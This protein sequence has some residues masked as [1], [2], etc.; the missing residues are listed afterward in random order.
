[1]TSRL[2]LRKALRDLRRRRSQIAAV[3]VT[4]FLGILLFAA[5]YDAASNLDASYHEVYDRLDFADVWATGG[6]TDEIVAELQAD[7]DVTAIGTRTRFDA[8]LRIGD[9]ELVGTVIGMPTDGEPPLNRLWVL[10]GRYFEPGDE[11]TG[12][13]IIEQHAR[14]EFDLAPGDAIGILGDDG[15]QELELTGAAASAEYVWLAPNRQQLFTV[16][17]EF[18]VVFVPEPVARDL[19]PEVPL[20][21]VAGVVDHRDDTA[22]RLVAATRSAGA[23]DA[24]TRSEQASNVTLQNDVSGFEQ[25][26]FVFPVLFL[27]VAGIAALVLLSRLVRTER[28]QIGMMVANG[29]S[30]RAIRAHYTTHALVAVL[31]GAIPGLILGALLGRW[32]SS[33]YTAFLDIPVTVTHFSPATIMISLAFAVVVTALAG[34]LPARAAA[35]IR[36]AEAM[37][38]PTPRAVTRRSLVERLWPGSLPESV[39]MVVRNVTRNRRRFVST[40]A[41]V[42]LALMMIITSLGLADT[43]AGAF[44]EQFDEVDLRDLTVTFDAPVTD[45]ELAQLD[46]RSDVATAERFVELPVVF[47]SPDGTSDQLLQ[48]FERDTAAHGFKTALPADGI[49]LSELAAD[50]L[51]VDIGD[52]ITVSVPTLGGEE[53]PSE[54]AGGTFRFDATVSGIVDEPVPSISYTSIDTWESVGAPPTH[55]AVL[56]LTDPSSHEA[57]RDAIQAAPGI[58]AVVD[59]QATESALRD[60]MALTYLF[61]ALMLAFSVIMAIALVYNM[62]SVSLAERTGEVAALRANGVGHRFIRRTVTTENLLTMLAGIVPGTIVGL[63]LARSFLQQFDTDSITFDFVLHGRSLALAIG[64]VLVSAIVAQWPGLRALR[65]LN[66]A[67]VVRERS[68]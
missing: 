12:A 33:Q 37:R 50:D 42:V 66:I 53:R 49:V 6:P 17:D 60:L 57:A 34:G 67:S 52:E 51:D 45:A 38:P 61:I 39:R 24:Y 30:T 14:D 26:A 4:V 47:E 55:R 43:T 19:A 32:V 16:P 48:V 22:A 15:W 58:A 7:P 54:P 18:A 31:L 20:Q 21:V 3:A 46:A 36:P 65:R 41:G 29:M 25:L 27:T 56:T 62:V 5:N 23:A 40:A 9:R 35:R 11:A 8:P 13:A 2:L 63:L 28:P 64:L 44:D 1:M 59:Q 68:E 10:D